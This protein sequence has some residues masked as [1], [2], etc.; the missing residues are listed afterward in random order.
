[1]TISP[2]TTL[3]DRYKRKLA[4]DGIGDETYKWVWIQENLGRPDLNAKDFVREIKLSTRTNLIYHNSSAVLI[5]MA[6]ERPDE[7]KSLLSD[8]FDESVDLQHRL[9][10]YMTVSEAIYVQ[11]RTNQTQSLQDERSASLLLAMRYPDKYP[12]Y[13]EKLYKKLCSDLGI[14]LQKPRKKYVDYIRLVDEFV[15]NHISHDKE[16]IDMVRSELPENAYPDPNYLILAQD[17]LYQNYEGEASNKY[18]EPDPNKPRVWLLS[19]GTGASKWREFQEKGV[20]SIG[21]GQTGD[22]SQMKDRAGVISRMQELWSEVGKNDTLACFEFAHVMKPDDYIIT[23]RGLSEYVGVG[24]VRSD[25]RFDPAVPDDHAHVRDV[26]WLKSG[27]WKADGQLAMKTLTDITKYP[28]YV[29]KLKE[30]IGFD[31]DP[32][33]HPPPGDTAHWWLNANPKYWSLSDHAVGSLQTYTTHAESG[34]KRR[35]Y[36]YFEALKPGDQIIGYETTPR[37]R[38][39]ARLVVTQGIHKDEEDQEC[40][41]FRVDTFYPNRPSWEELLAESK[42]AKAEIFENNQGSLFQLTKDEFEHIESLAIGSAKSRTPYTLTDATSNS[43]LDPLWLTDTLE[44]WRTKL[45]LVL[46]GPPGTGKTFVAKRLAWLLMGE[47]DESRLHMVQ[48]HPSYSYED[49]IEGYRPNGQ[50]GFILKSG[51]FLSFCRR[52]ASDPNRPYVFIIDEINRGNLSKVFGEVM[53]GIEADKRGEA[54]HL[55]YS[56]SDSPFSIPKN[57]H[58]IGTMNTADRSLALV[59]YA[60]RRRFAFQTVSPEF[61]NNFVAFLESKS[62]PTSII[63]QITHGLK[64]LNEMIEKDSSLGPGYLVGHSYFCEPPAIAHHVWLDR[65]WKYEVLPLME[66]YWFDQTDEVKKVKQLLAIP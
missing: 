4:Y 32:E 44:L 25:Y 21:W 14:E 30:Q 57:V 37:K 18:V 45:N 13:K 35:V 54:I 48:F 28:D 64:S 39:V 40:I 19:P 61:G 16:L 33:S 49:F 60:L 31:E 58:L 15:E 22:L 9:E 36:K 46:Q 5:H 3:I 38:V 65:I 62:V 27:S 26:T 34:N 24:M 55:Q 63:D 8:L 6:V 42:L 41:E 11:I 59:D 53:M 12:L 50:S 20:A 43:F 10:S 47:K 29:R 52:A 23:K 1:M 66:E 2:Y 51:H 17:I 7:L 56:L